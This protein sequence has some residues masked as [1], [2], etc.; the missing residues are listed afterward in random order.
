MA[1]VTGLTA[2]ATAALV[3]TAKSRANHTGTQTASTISDLT[4][5]MQ[6][7][8]AST[9]VAGTNITRVYDDTAGTITLSS[10]A[11]GGGGSTSSEGVMLSTYTAGTGTAA[12]NTTGIQNWINAAKTAKKPAINDLGG[13][14]VNI[15]SI[16]DMVGD[17]LV[18]RG[19]GLRL[20][21]T[22]NTAGGIRVGSEAQN[23]DGLVVYFSGNPS[24]ANTAANGVEFA[25]PLC[26]V[27]SNLIVQNGARG[28]YLPQAVPANGDQSSNTVFSCVFYN[29]RI[30][31]YSI[32]AIEMQTYPHGGAASTGSAW[33]NV[34]IHNNWFG[35]N[36][37]PSSWPV[38]FR[39]FDEGVFNQF[40]VEWSN[41]PSDAIFLQECQGMT[42]NS[43]HFEGIQLTGNSA[44]FRTY[45]ATRAE[46]HT[47]MAKSITIANDTGQKSLFRGYSADGNP[48]G[49]DVTNV[50]VDSTTNSGAKPFGLC[51]IES[52]STNLD[53]IFRRVDLTEFT[54]AVI[55][56]PTGFVP[57]QVEAYN[58]VRLRSQVG[59]N[60]PVDKVRTTAA[61]AI[62][63][64]TLVSDTTLT[65]P[66][67]VG[68]Y[69]VDG[70]LIFTAPAA[71]DLSL[72][73]NCTGTA[74]GKFSMTSA[75]TAV[76]AMPAAGV[77]NTIGIN[78]TTTIGGVDS[79]EQALHFTGTLIVTA[80]GVFTIQYAEAV[81]S[82]SLSPAAAL[83]RLS[84][85]KIS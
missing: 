35:S 49:V 50:R 27:Y 42:F 10:T 62:T 2:D 63:T 40:N 25:N 43:L 5:V 65:F 45:Y 64:T 3:D 13:I 32:A 29:I 30:S 39:N 16:I 82:G 33:I 67:A 4:E 7:L 69:I 48:G 79:T 46:V 68:T 85:R 59:P 41:P 70:L 55:V 6:D 31:G 21:Q 38:T 74:T 14:D 61:S 75:G 77:F 24:S 54:G 1:T 58:D 18:V 73:F 26:S 34:Y 47:M 76:T 8:M 15:S 17:H 83:S 66:T 71:A 81:A 52:G 57:A 37:T 9:I 84:Y 22:V 72:R 53:F 44:L 80:T 23:I 11:S 56:D 60:I 19:N 20:V 78:T 36:G 12:A 28:F 51:E